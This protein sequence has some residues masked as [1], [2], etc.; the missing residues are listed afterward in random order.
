MYEISGVFAEKFHPEGYVLRMKGAFKM[1]LNTEK[2]VIR[3]LREQR[4]F[5]GLTVKTLDGADQTDYFVAKVEELD[6]AE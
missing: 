5:A 1:P 4:P 6:R 3:F 2:G